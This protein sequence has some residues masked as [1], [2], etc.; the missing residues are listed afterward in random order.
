MGTISDKL[1]YLDGTREQIKENLNKFGSNITENDTFRSYSNVIN[2]IYDKLPKVSGNGS[3]FSLENA[4]NGKL[5]SFGMDG[6]TEQTT[7][8]GKNLFD[9]TDTSEVGTGASSFWV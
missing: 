4:Q 5:D 7:Y 6:N 3:N 9:Y 8:S 2:D 1:V